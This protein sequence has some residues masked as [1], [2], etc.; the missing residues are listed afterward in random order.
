ME[1]KDKYSLGGTVFRRLRDDIL[2]GRYEKDEELKENTIA[3]ELGVSRTPVREALRQL[4]LEGL[5]T[6]IPNKGAYATGISHKDVHDIYEIRSYLEGLA[7]RWETTKMTEEQF[8][9][10]EEIIYLT[11]FHIKKQHMEQVVELDNKFHALLYKNSGSRFL[12]HIL[13]DFHQYVESVR[14]ISLRSGGRAEKSNEEHRAML[15]AMRARNAAKAEA[16]A[17]EHII[18]AKD[19]LTKHGL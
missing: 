19:N 9:E 13:V 2:M 5:V 17:H 18:R 3:Q 4:E 15:E 10:M 7:A 16:L 8:E 12:E 6:I 14:K 1:K 11:D